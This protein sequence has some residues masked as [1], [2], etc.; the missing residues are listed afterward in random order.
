MD[1]AAPVAVTRPSL[2]EV[3][4]YH[5]RQLNEALRRP[6]MWGGE[7]TILVLMD[8]MAFVDGLD[9]IVREETRA[10]RARQAFNSLG[11]RG[12]FQDAL[13]GYQGE[14][15]AAASVYAEIA[16]RYDWLVVDRVIPD[17]VHERLRTHP[18]EWCAHDRRLDDVL[19]ELGPPS[20]LCGG[21]SPC[22]PKT[23]VYAAE[24]GPGL[25]SLH[26]SGSPDEPEPILSALRYGDGRF[27]ESFV[28][29]P[30]GRAQHVA[31]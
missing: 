5:L 12:G 8:A 11:V 22:W 27:P 29:T 3:R 18:A 20:V 23:L 21:Y 15:E 30:F 7:V 16:W 24:A 13:P 4:Q 26:F 1:D 14:Q 17:E 19:S 6:G 31:G 10:L 9:K 28:F 25:V 2:A